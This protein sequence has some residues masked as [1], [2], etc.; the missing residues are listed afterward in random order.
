MHCE[1]ITKFLQNGLAFV[2]NV[3]TMETRFAD[4][5]VLITNLDKRSIMQ[6]DIARLI[7]YF[8]GVNAL[9]AAWK[10]H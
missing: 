7:D 4:L 2:Q 5:A 10:E 3:T 6:L 1:I 8:G 9:A